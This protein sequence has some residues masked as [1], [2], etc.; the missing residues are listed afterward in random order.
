MKKNKKAAIHLAIGIPTINQWPTLQNFLKLYKRDFPSIP[1]Y[2]YDNGRQGIRAD[3]FHLIEAGTNQGVAGAWNNLAEL[4]FKKGATHLLLLNDDIYLGRRREEVED[5]LHREGRD[6][7]LGVASQWSSFVLPRT[8]FEKVGTFDAGFFPAYFEDNDY[9][10]RL[11]L[12]GCRLY[13]DFKLTPAIYRVSETIKK[14]PSLNANFEKN[15]LRYVEKWG[16]LPG[17]EQF[18]TPYTAN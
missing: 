1:I 16:G 18:R 17:K 4:A 5:L 12:K 15:K 8:T 14:D 3:G 11:K 9:E 6:L 10:Y 13:S 7:L 2:V